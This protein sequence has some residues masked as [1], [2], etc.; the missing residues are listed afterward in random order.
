MNKDF[1]IDIRTL[2]SFVWTEDNLELAKIF[3]KRHFFLQA[4]GSMIEVGPPRTEKVQDKF[5]QQLHAREVALLR[6]AT[7]APTS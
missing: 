1:G 3:R 7:S 5:S 6:D 2:N 4:D